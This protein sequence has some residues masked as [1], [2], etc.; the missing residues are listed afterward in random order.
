MD[1]KTQ[2][3]IIYILVGLVILTGLGVAIVGVIKKRKKLIFL[4]VII[5][6]LPTLISMLW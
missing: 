1:P 6:I 3:L 4:G 2:Y 5:A